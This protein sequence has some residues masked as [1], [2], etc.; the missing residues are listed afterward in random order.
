VV[1]LDESTE[2]CLHGFATGECAQCLANQRSTHHSGVDRTGREKLLIYCSTISAET[3]LHF[4]RQGESYRLRAFVGEFAGRTA[5]V[6]P[7]ATRASNFLRI[8]K[9]EHLID[10]EMEGV[11]VDRTERWEEI[12]VS[13]NRRLG[14]GG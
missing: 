14:I 12:V 4:N 6:Q 2:L 7:D 1:S 13:H 11:A 3:L 5:W 9:P 10:V 8:Y